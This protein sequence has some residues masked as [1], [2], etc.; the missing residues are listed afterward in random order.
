MGRLTD[1]GR[2][3]ILADFHVGKSQNELAKIY[4]VSP[5]TINKLCKG[6][7][8]KNA[9][10]VNI[11]AAIKTEM[12]DQSEYEVNAIH[13]EVDERTKYIQFFTHAAVHNVRHAVKKINPE[14]TQA[15]HRLLA[16]TILKGKEAVLGREP[17][18]A[19]QINNDRTDNQP[20]RVNFY[21][22]LNGRD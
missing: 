1:E 10:K 18:T 9:D 2:A 20:G 21:I 12:A 17:S 15:E 6:L 16:D 19:V 7:V 14:T 8:P 22:P 4:S 3:K 5:A 11:L 13:R